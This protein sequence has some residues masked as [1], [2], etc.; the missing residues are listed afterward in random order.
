MRDVPEYCAITDVSCQ[1]RAPLVPHTAIP[2][3]PHTAGALN[4]S[5]ARAYKRLLLYHSASGLVGPYRNMVGPRKK[6]SLVVSP[7]AALIACS[8][9]GAVQ[10]R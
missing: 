8:C 4:E 3:I 2:I 9:G 1:H 10:V 5:E 6:T 7:G